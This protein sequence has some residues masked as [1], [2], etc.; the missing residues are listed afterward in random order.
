MHFGLI[1]GSFHTD[2]LTNY[3]LLNLSRLFSELSVKRY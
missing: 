1:M 3:N 2:G